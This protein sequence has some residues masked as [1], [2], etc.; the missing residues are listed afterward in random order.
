M[1]NAGTQEIVFEQE[2]VY[3]SEKQRTIKLLFELTGNHVQHSIEYG[4][5]FGTK[6]K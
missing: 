3:S 1:L 4:V 5:H 6:L 2:H